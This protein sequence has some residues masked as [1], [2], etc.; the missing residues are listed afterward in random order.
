[1]QAARASVLRGGT[2]PPS[3]ATRVRRYVR[4]RALTADGTHG[5]IA[6]HFFHCRLPWTSIRA[7]LFPLFASESLRLYVRTNFEIWSMDLTNGHLVTLSSEPI[8]L[9]DSAWR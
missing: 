5:A 9:P 3:R 8:G 1:M 2:C 7:S 4:H 6:S